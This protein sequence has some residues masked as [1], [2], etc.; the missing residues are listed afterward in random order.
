QDFG[1]FE[2]VLPSALT[3]QI[4][5]LSL[6]RGSSIFRFLLGSYFLTLQGLLPG[7]SVTVSM[8]VKARKTP[9]EFEQ[10]GCLI[11][12]LPV[13]MAANGPMSISEY[14]ALSDRQID[15]ALRHD[16]VPGLLLLQKWRMRRGINRYVAPKTIFNFL[17][18]GDDSFHLNGLLLERVSLGDSRLSFMGEDALIRLFVRFHKEKLSRA[19][20]EVLMDSWISVMR[21]CVEGAVFATYGTAE[22]TKTVYAFAGGAGGFDEHARLHRMEEG[23][24]EGFRI[25]VLP[26]PEAG[27]GRLPGRG[28]KELARG[29]A[30]MIQETAP[31]GRIWLMGEGLGAID[32]FA[33][34]CALQEAGLD[35]V[36]LILVDPVAPTPSTR[37]YKA[38]SAAIDA[39][40]RIPERVSHVQE[41]LFDIRLKAATSGPLRMRLHPVPRSRRQ[42][43][44]SAMA[45][46]LFD[47]ESYRERYDPASKETAQELFHRYLNEGWQAGHHPSEG[48]QA[49]RYGALEEAFT[50]GMDEP[51]LHALWFG[52]R[53]ARTRRRILEGLGRPLERSE[54]LSARSR[55]RLEGYKPGLF[56]GHVYLV[57]TGEVQET[58]VRGQWQAMVKGELYLYTLHR[59][60]HPDAEVLTEILRECLGVCSTS[61]KVSDPVPQLVV[62][63]I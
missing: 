63:S 24:G 28:V 55:L 29:Y 5:S 57:M 26:D 14:L 54:L 20:V 39:Y 33:V 58:D 50:P 2:F 56:Q 23:P 7:R 53:T 46:D 35:D 16:R 42:V 13:T 36:G 9:E 4:R 12:S 17:E 59:Q 6:E 62:S 41:T 44:R 45:Y 27:F 19:Q 47:P 60:S 10:V 32:A 38:V 37:N 21:H 52:M 1:S 11:N 40:G 61:G 51:V 25:Q 48:F 31:Q 8:P 3:R 15:D 30:E 22:I 43:W 49:V 18:A 34:G